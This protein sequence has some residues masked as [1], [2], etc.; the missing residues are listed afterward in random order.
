MATGHGRFDKFDRLLT[1]NDGWMQHNLL[2]F[3]K[4]LTLYENQEILILS[5]SHVVVDIRRRR[6]YMNWIWSDL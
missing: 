4:V 1:E 5:Q 3:Q 6:Q 2:S